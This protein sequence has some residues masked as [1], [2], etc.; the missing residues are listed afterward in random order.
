MGVMVS[1]VIDSKVAQKR[2]R[3]AVDK[4]REDAVKTQ[5][6][7]ID[8]FLPQWIMA[9]IEALAKESPQKNPKISLPKEKA[10][11]L[12]NKLIQEG[13]GI[14]LW[15]ESCKPALNAP[16]VVQAIDTAYEKYPEPRDPNAPYKG[17]G[18]GDGKG[19]GKGWG[20]NAAMQDGWNDGMNM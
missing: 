13:A 5:P 6:A 1:K 17:K 3:D 14:P 16:E 12:F 4:A 11:E 18:K 8:A 19:D 7:N 20:K 9:S 2:T 15:L 10:I